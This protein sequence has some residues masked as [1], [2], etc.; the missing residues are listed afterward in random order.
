MHSKVKYKQYSIIK[1]S[2]GDEKYFTSFQ[3]RAFRVAY[4]KFRLGVLPLNVNLYR[5]NQ[6]MTKQNCKFCLNCVE[7]ES[8]FMLYC[9]MYCD[10][11]NI[12]LC[13]FETKELMHLMLCQSTESQLKIA[14]FIYYALKKRKTII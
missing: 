1:P 8:H 5:F 6:D 7:D 13:E 9:P 14:K 2:P 10:L 11:R 12:F 4:S 3:V